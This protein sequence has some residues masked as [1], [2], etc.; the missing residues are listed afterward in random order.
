MLRTL[1]IAVGI[2][3][4]TAP[5]WPNAGASILEEPVANE[6]PRK[7]IGYG[8]IAFRGKGPEAWH[9]QTVLAHREIAQLRRALRHRSSSLEAISLASTTYGIDYW[10]LRRKAACESRFNPN[11]RNPMSTASGLFQFLTS[12]WQTTPYRRQSIWSPYA[13][14]LAA[15][16]MHARGRGNEWSC[17]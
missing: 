7:K 17:R 2:F 8:Q 9:W 3:A 16:W 6:A 10:M 14:A 15:G 4:L 13:N 11:A 12:T 5:W 1:V